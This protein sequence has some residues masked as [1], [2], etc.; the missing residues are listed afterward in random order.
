MHKITPSVDYNKWLRRLDTQPNKAI[1]Q[2]SL[3][4]P[5]VDKPTNKKTIV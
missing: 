2:N 1:N 3:K 4:V 5:K